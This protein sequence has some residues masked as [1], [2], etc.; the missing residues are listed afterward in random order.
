MTHLSAFV[1]YPDM[2]FAALTPY[3]ATSDGF[4]RE[5]DDEFRKPFCLKV[6]DL[7]DQVRAQPDGLGKIRLLKSKREKRFS[8]NY[9][10]LPNT[11]RPDAV[12]ATG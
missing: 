10:Q 11:F 9:Y 2:G 7:F 3:I 6:Y 5:T 8:K 1:L 12:P 4:R